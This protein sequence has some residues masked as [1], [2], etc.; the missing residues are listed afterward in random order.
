MSL[1][2]PRE[3]GRCVDFHAGLL[4]QKVLGES[5]FGLFA[6]WFALILAAS[7][8]GLVGRWRWLQGWGV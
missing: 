4:L 1:S 8:G 7:F 3:K 5:V 6:A 2:C